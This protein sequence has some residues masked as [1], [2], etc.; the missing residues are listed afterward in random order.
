MNREILHSIWSSFS[1]TKADC[2]LVSEK[3]QE[4]VCKVSGAVEAIVLSI[5]SRDEELL[6]ENG[7]LA[8]WCICVGNRKC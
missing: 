8:V 6:I 7:C 2:W 4:D 1:A 3:N 5:E